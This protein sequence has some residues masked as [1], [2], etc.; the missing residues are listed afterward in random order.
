MDHTAQ[1]RDDYLNLM[2]GKIV[3]ADVWLEQQMQFLYRAFLGPSIAA[4][5]LTPDNFR[6]LA[7]GARRMM[8]SIED[9]ADRDLAN[10]AL[11]RARAA[12]KRRA[13]IVHDMWL[14]RG[15]SGTESMAW[16]ALRMVPSGRPQTLTDADLATALSD[17]NRSAISIGMLAQK[18]QAETLQIPPDDD[19]MWSARELS[20][21]IAGDIIF[22]SDGG[23]VFRFP[24]QEGPG[25]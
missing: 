23:R 20:A 16:D 17:L 15:E 11:T 1:E 3:R 5:R 6:D 18:I 12:H 13:E 4:R 8:A 21:G 10:G 25:S 22:L 2:I 24:W 14:H 9:D 7:E 19:E